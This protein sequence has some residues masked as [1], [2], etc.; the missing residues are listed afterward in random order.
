MSKRV[1]K[2]P[3][4]PAAAKKVGKAAGKRDDAPI[5]K[6]ILERLR[7][8]DPPVKQLGVNPPDPAMGVYLLPL[9][10]VCYITTRSDA[11]REETAL[12]T[13]GGKTFYSAMTLD[14]IATRLKEHPHFM[15]T[16]RFHLVNLTNVR[17][18]RMSS[19]RDLWFEG[20][21][22][23]LINAV[24]DTYKDLFDAWANG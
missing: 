14:A 11:G 2:A 9:A 8:I 24:T 16:S 17:A 3:A 18:Y 23:P 7:S 20:I 4:K 12:V 15:K 1:G 19:A 10:E 5:L 22:E 21:K 6:A 13:K